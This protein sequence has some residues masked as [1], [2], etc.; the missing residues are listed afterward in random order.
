[1]LFCCSLKMKDE[2]FEEVQEE[3]EQNDEDGVFFGQHSHS[4]SRG[5]W[6]S[7]SSCRQHHRLAA[8]PGDHHGGRYGRIRSKHH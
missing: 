1:M 8:D 2:E 3:R 6:W 5:L 7:Y 4:L